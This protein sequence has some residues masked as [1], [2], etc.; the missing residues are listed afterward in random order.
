MPGN[1]NEAAE[2]LDAYLSAQRKRADEAA[3]AGTRGTQGG[4]TVS[5][6]SGPERSSAVGFVPGEQQ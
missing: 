3:R 2:M 6:S 4:Q 1:E 5:H